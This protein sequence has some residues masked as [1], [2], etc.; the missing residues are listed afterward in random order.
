MAYRDVPA[1]AANVDAVLDT[2]S[3]LASG[4]RA[5]LACEL[6]DHALDRIGQALEEIDNSDGHGMSLLECARDIHLAAVCQIKPEPIELARELF[7][8]EMADDYGIFDGAVRRYD[9]V[10]GVAGLAE[11]RRL[12]SAAWE[13]TAPSGGRKAQQDDDD[14]SVDRHQVMRILDFFAERDG[15]VDARIA[16]RAVTC[17][18]NRTTTDSP[19][20]ACSTAA[21]RK[22][23][24]VPRRA[25]GFSR[26]RVRTRGS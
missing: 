10:L 24:G 6:A 15:D 17:R 19:N 1:W 9:D 22:R 13:K 23:C 2:V 16:L 20:S 18:P 11:Y 3:G 21:R 8:R 26:T 12:A 25:C 5:G 7:A 14:D 4:A